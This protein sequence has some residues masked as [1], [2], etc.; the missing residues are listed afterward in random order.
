MH[1]PREKIEERRASAGGQVGR[2]GRLGKW[3]ADSQVNM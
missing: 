1:S 2:I 3:I